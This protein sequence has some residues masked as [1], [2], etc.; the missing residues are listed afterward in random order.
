M[1]KMCLS[2]P[3]P[4]YPQTLITNA[5]GWKIKVGFELFN[6]PVAV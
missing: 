6:Q 5:G 2:H 3:I 4:V 1:L